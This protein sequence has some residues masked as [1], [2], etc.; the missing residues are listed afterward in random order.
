M[1][2]RSLLLGDSEGVGGSCVFL[3]SVSQMVGLLPAHAGGT[4]RAAATQ[5]RKSPDPLYLSP[6]LWACGG[7]GWGLVLTHPGCWLTPA[8]LPSS[9]ERSPVGGVLPP[10][11]G[12]PQRVCVFPAAFLT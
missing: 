12:P 5:T 9:T 1:F 7:Q 6:G 2:P 11:F 8:K 4:S 10:D 3:F